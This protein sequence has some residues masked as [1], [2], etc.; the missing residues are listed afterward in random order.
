M[1]A[2]GNGL[3]N[4]PNFSL[5]IF[6]VETGTGFTAFARMMPTKHSFQQ[7]TER[8]DDDTTFAMLTKPAGLTQC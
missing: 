2:S 4:F 3:G 6:A 5:G 1:T 7:L 8:D